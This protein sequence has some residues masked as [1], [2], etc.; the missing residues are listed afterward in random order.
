MTCHSCW[1]PRHPQEFV[2]AK[3]DKQSVPWSRPE[4]EDSFVGV[5]Y[6]EGISGYADLAVASCMIAENDTHSVTFLIEL[7]DGPP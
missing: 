6:I 2:R 3:E 1:E 5:C 7:S 4:A